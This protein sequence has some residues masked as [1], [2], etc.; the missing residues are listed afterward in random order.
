[1]AIAAA[2]IASF[3]A[4]AAASVP[5]VGALDL[6]HPDLEMAIPARAPLLSRGGMFGVPAPGADR[7]LALPV[8]HGDAEPVRPARRLHAEE[9]RLFARELHHAIRRGGVAVVV[10]VAAQRTEHHRVVRRWGGVGEGRG[11]GGGLRSW[12]G[13]DAPQMS[14]GSGDRK[15]TRLNSSH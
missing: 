11:H 6:R 12:R 4:M 9:S 8:R 1:M 5:A 15:S 10:S 13:N 14:R 2:K 3:D 7:L